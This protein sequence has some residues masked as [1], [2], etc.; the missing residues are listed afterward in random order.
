[1]TRMD[2]PGGLAHA[3]G[4]GRFEGKVEDGHRRKAGLAEG[5]L[6]IGAEEQVE[7]RLIRA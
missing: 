3:S 4:R 6:E 5:L 7:L 1:M 2:E